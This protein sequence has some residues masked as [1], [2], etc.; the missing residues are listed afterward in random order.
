MGTDQTSPNIV[1]ESA[2]AILTVSL[3]R[4]EKKNALSLA[5]YTA[6]ASALRAGDSDSA[7]RAV[8]LQ[9]TADCFTSGNDIADFVSNPTPE[10]LAP[11][12]DFLGVLST[13]GK[14]VVA[15]VNGLAVGIGTTMLLHCDLV[16]CGEGARFQLPFVNLGLVPEAASSLLLPR[17]AGYHRAAELLMLGEMFSAVT[18]REIGLVNRVTPDAECQ[19]AAREFAAKLASRPAAAVRLT[20]SLLKHN[21]VSA[22]R[23]TIADEASHFAARLQSPEAAEAFA[24]FMERRKPDFSKFQ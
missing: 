23:N 4:P 6:L 8:V 18:A 2:E 12:F 20:K 1:V 7:V 15:A 24:A 17:L 11:I 22:I 13:L 9:G 3:R 21:L 10:R 14:P 16:C 19:S 5:M